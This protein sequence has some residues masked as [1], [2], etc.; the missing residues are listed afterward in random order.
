MRHISFKRATRLEK[1]IA[2]F[3]QPTGITDFSSL[4]IVDEDE[5][6]HPNSKAII[7]ASKKILEGKAELLK[8][9]K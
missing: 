9:L 8:L 1:S 3:S 7:E 5:Q 4:V 2:M 6:E